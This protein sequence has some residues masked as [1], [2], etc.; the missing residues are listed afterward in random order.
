V[1]PC[2]MF[3]VVVVSSS[4]AAVVVRQQQLLKQYL[5]ILFLA[6]NHNGYMSVAVYWCK[7]R[8]WIVV[9]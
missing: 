7:C 6:N 5:G 2:V 3:H 4:S 8:W 9:L 1:A